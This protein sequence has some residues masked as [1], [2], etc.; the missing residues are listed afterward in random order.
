MDKPWIKNYE[1][2]VRANLD[3]PPVPLH[4]FLENTVA[5]FPNQVVTIFGSVVHQLGGAL[6]DATMTYK[7]LDERVNRLA[8]ALMA[9][10]VKKGDRVAIFLP[11]CP[12]FVITYYAI[13]KI[14]AIVSPNNPLY[15]ARELEH[16][17]NDSGSETIICLS[18]F[19][20][21]V[22]QVRARTKLKNVIVANIKE[23]FPPV[24][25][26]LFGLGPEKK[27]GHRVTLDAGD[28]WFQ[29]V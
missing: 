25:K 26:F 28:K 27:E 12:Q 1:A 3:Y 19:Y 9:M 18:R 14:G 5:K 8:N 23:Y 21:T 16:Q 4:Q 6:M 24:L 20:P 11:N 2:G 7:E 29:D 17:L 22:Q 13:L 15:V 10:G